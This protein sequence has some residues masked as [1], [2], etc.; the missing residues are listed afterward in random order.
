MAYYTYNNNTGD[1]IQVSEEL[2]HNG[3]PVSGCAV[4]F[5]N[6]TIEEIETLYVWDRELRDFVLKQ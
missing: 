4:T 6:L 5:T 1:L 2:L 3:S